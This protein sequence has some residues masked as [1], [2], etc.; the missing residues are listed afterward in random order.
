MGVADVFVTD[1]FTGNV[2]MKLSEGLGE[3]IKT[4]LKEEITADP[5]SSVGGLLIKRA[6]TRIN[7]RTSYEEIGG[8]PLLGVDGVVII[9]HGRSTARAIRSAILRAGE[10]VKSGVVDSI[11]KG[12]ESFP[13]TEAKAA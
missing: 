5:V 12:L 2:I 7:K 9:G 13:A 4:M 11:K 6:R 10:S 8:A 3:F 1:G